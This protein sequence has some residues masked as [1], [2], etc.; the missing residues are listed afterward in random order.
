MIIVL[1]FCAFFILSSTGLVPIIE[2]YGENDIPTTELRASFARTAPDYRQM[3]LDHFT[4][5][6][7][8]MDS[9]TNDVWST[10]DTD[11]PAEAAM[12]PLASWLIEDDLNGRED[13]I[14]QLDYAWLQCQISPNMNMPLNTLGY[15]SPDFNSRFITSNYVAYKI[16]GNDTF[17]QRA[18]D[19]AITMANALNRSSHMVMG[20]QVTTFYEKY[21]NAYPIF[22]EDNTTLKVIPEMNARIGVA[23]S[24][25]YHEPSSSY[26]HNNTFLNIAL[27][28][29][30]A[31]LVLQNTTSGSFARHEDHLL[32][33]ATANA[34][35]TAM[36]L[37]WA[38]RLW[39]FPI[40]STAVMKASSWLSQ[41]MTPGHISED[42]TPTH[43]L[44]DPDPMEIWWRLPLFHSTGMECSNYTREILYSSLGLNTSRL[45]WPFCTFNVMGVP[46]S[47][48]LLNYDRVE[49]EGTIVDGH[50]I[51]T[52]L[53]NGITNPGF[54]RD[55][56][57]DWTYSNAVIEKVSPQ[58]HK[59][60][61][62]MRIKE[63]GIIDEE[64]YV[65]QMVSLQPST[66][67][68]LDFR[69][70][71]GSDQPANFMRVKVDFFDANDNPVGTSEQWDEP[72]CLCFWNSPFE[73]HTF[74]TPP[75]AVKLL[76]KFI[77]YNGVA[78]LDV[79]VDSVS[80]VLS[81]EES[82]F[83]D[84]LDFH[85]FDRCDLSYRMTPG[86]ID[87]NSA[88]GPRWEQFLIS[89]YDYT[90]FVMEF[91]IR[92]KEVVSGVEGDANLIYGSDPRALFNRY[93]LE[94]TPQSGDMNWHT[95]KLHVHG[96]AMTL[97]LDG[98]LLDTGP[99]I[100]GTPLACG[101]VGFLHEGNFHLS[102]RNIL[103]YALYDIPLVSG[104]NL[105]SYPIIPSTNI[106]SE[107]LD[108]IDGSYSIARTYSPYDV[109]DPWKAY[110]PDFPVGFNDLGALSHPSGLWL[111]TGVD[112]TFVVEGQ[113]GSMVGTEFVFG[114]SSYVKQGW[115]L[116]G[117]PSLTS[118]KVSDA[119]GDHWGNQL[120]VIMR[121]TPGTG[122][123][124]ESMSSD[125]MLQP[126]VGYWVYCS[127]EFLWQIATV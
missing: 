53:R 79:L 86:S 69:Y 124:L 123:D 14:R 120:E 39:G 12:I 100:S 62:S 3:N 44:N 35:S 84:A 68:S 88:G 126:G 27:E 10:G 31:T 21:T 85:W 4:A 19:C 104:W 102:I 51:Y 57:G 115:S 107:Q 82:A 75:N 54:E 99:T 118:M 109:N 15:V 58:A 98:M 117:Y 25:L 17:L 36:S 1:T 2:S 66:Q 80:L 63:N 20:Q 116:L 112:T 64:D 97:S 13:A 30:N 95:Y 33:A 24:L 8:D 56:Y 37:V 6:H 125:D 47:V 81:T 38:E 7:Q 65:A 101:R 87:V 11:N 50:T 89:T 60:L 52:S 108:P 48:Y 113:V 77:N 91:D 110:S 55:I 121:K 103:V 83:E 94:I 73:P 106:I 61:A 71:T 28:E 59:G 22:I 32:E 127:E 18:Q 34:S 72:P 92:R 43:V 105:I 46:S 16:L 114:M 96:G 49:S 67:Y 122:S 45:D 70:L 9:K 111:K 40:Y 76:L 90:D 42:F 74:T 93:S 26:F 29:L 78:G 119:F 41:W 23:Y 5:L